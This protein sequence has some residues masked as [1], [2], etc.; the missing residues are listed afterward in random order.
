M[1]EESKVLVAEENFFTSLT[2]S[3]VPTLDNILAPDFILIDLSGSVLDRVALLT[4]IESGEL[5]FCRYSSN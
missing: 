4:V 1:S 5:K 3:N 2:H